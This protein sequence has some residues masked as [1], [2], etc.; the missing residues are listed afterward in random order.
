MII[1]KKG[2]LNQSIHLSFL[3]LIIYPF[4]YDVP[5]FQDGLLYYVIQFF[6]LAVP[7]FLIKSLFFIASSEFQNYVYYVLYSFILQFKH[8]FTSFYLITDAGC[9]LKSFPSLGAFN[10]C[11]I[12]HS[13]LKLLLRH[14]Y[15]R[16]HQFLILYL[17]ICL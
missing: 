9:K 8:Q 14:S 13:F 2:C 7:K 11:S 16:N 15:S 5:P 17:I 3:L 4:L 6:V 10:L 12:F 1:P